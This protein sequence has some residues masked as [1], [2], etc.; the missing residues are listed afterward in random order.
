MSARDRDVA[1]HRDDGDPV[2][3]GL[4]HLGR[5]GGLARHRPIIERP[6]IGLPIADRRLGIVGAL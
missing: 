3:I 1:S 2:L 6:V 5:A 4:D